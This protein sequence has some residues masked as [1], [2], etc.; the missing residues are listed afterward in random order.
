MTFRLNLQP[1][2]LSL[3]AGHPPQVCY[4]LLDIAASAAGSVPP[5]INWALV[6]D[7]SA[8]MRIPIVSDEQFRQLVRADSAEEVLVDGVP[9][10]QFTTP[11]PP[12]IKQ[13]APSALAYVGRAVQSVVEWLDSADRFSLVACAEDAVVLVSAA[14]GAQ[15]GA[16][17]QGIQ[18]LSE[19]DLGR[20]TSL[21]QGLHLAWDELVRGRASGGG[22]PQ[23]ERVL[24]L[25]D[26]FTRKPEACLHLARQLA[27]EGITITTL[28]LGGDFHEDVLTALADVSGG[29]ALFLHTPE[30]IPHAIEQELAAARAVAVRAVT[31]HLHCIG[32][33]VL[34]RV[35]RMQPALTMLEPVPTTPTSMVLH[36]GDLMRQITLLLELLVPPGVAGH[37]VQCVAHGSTGT[38]SHTAHADIVAHARAEAPP[39]PTALLDAITRANAAHLQQRAIAASAQGDYVHAAQCFRQVAA[40]FTTLGEAYLAAAALREAQSLEQEQQT[41]RLGVKELTYAARRQEHMEQVRTTAPD[42]KR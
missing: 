13:A 32:G 39:L 6:A 37:L 12:A 29:Q 4:V 36:L 30:T 40:R 1:D 28:G 16:V 15:R 41:T 34:R 11:V 38:Q 35:T 21:G 25:T 42:R 17:V 9:V 14:S 10:W 31:L 7:A 18:R 19:L 26:G 33:V 24:L 22:A 23:V 8:S 5:A 27:A 3:Q 2:T 20:E